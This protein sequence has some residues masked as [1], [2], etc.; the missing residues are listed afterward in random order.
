MIYKMDYRDANNNKLKDTVS[1]KS[2]AK[3]DK[4]VRRKLE[5]KVGWL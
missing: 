1:S 5:K 2:K 3:L 4:T